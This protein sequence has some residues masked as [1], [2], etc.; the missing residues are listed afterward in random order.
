MG[1]LIV[2]LLPCCFFCLFEVTIGYSQLNYYIVHTTFN[3]A[4]FR[5][6]QNTQSSA[7]LSLRDQFISTNGPFI[8]SF[9]ATLPFSDT[10]ARDFNWYGVDTN[11][12]MV[13]PSD[14]ILGLASQIQSRPFDVALGLQEFVLL[15]RAD[16]DITFCKGLESVKL[17]YD[18]VGLTSFAED[19]LSTED[20]N[21]SI[22]AFA[23][24][25]VSVCYG[26]ISLGINPYFDSSIGL[27]FL[28]SSSSPNDTLETTLLPSRATPDSIFQ[29]TQ[30]AG[31]NYEVLR[32][33]D[34]FT[35]E[36]VY[37]LQR[38]MPEPGTC[39]ILGPADGVAGQMRDSMASS[40][41]ERIDTK[42]CH[43]IGVEGIIIYSCGS[44]DLPAESSQISIFDLT[45]RAVRI[46]TLEKPISLSGLPA[47]IYAV[48]LEE[49]SLLFYWPAR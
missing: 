30:S 3:E 47:G 49:D 35:Y 19:D 42:F 17:V 16:S 26:S 18:H 32:I 4:F 10:L 2:K 13:Q 40:V 24:G 23:D 12:V 28:T 27:V 44:V 11:I 8:N 29:V 33:Q 46:G 38:F 34:L 43:T 6:S 15:Q 14:G 39:I 21:L 25:T 45:G 41:I 9:I 48:V 36:P 22:E 7:C 37:P 5:Q 20:V 1:K 31:G